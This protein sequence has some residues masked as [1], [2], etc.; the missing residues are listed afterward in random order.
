MS[1]HRFFANAAL[2][3]SAAGEEFVLPLASE[4]VHHAVRVL[5]LHQGDRIVVVSPERVAYECVLTRVSDPEGSTIGAGLYGEVIQR[6]TPI[7]EPRVTLIQGL[8]KAAKMDLIIEKAVEIGIEAIWPIAFARSV[9]RLD[10]ARAGKKGERWRRVAEAAAKQSGRSFVPQVLDPADERGLIGRF[11]QFHL[12]ILASEEHAGRAPGVGEVIRAASLPTDPQV[13]VIV[14]PEGG[15]T[16][17]EVAAFVGAQA[18]IVSL[19]DTI[20]R[21]ET[22]GIVLPALCVYE[23]GGL[24]GRSLD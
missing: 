23:L 10:S 5:R 14:G 19:G 21:T 4:D 12:V 7:L 9:V 3:A 6:V 8:P 15:F 2:P 13:A 16:P 20:L 24:G 22:A 17:Q 1:L 18:V 11:D